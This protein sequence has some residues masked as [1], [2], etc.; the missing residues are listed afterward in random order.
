MKLSKSFIATAVLS[1][2]SV[3]NLSYAQSAHAETSTAQSSISVS[4]KATL[5]TVEAVDQSEILLSVIALHKSHDM[6]FTH[7][8]KMMVDEHG[9]NLAQ[10]LEMAKTSTPLVSPKGIAIAAHGQNTLAKLGGLQ[11]K[12]FEVAY[13]NEMVA[14]HQAALDLLNEKLKDSADLP[15]IKQFLVDTQQA[16]Q[17]HLAHAK[18]LQAKL[19]S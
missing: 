9:N 11:G 17:K 7:F 14:G 6:R 12:A 8:A 13:I 10:L 5:A 18:K 2:L 16:V 15:N 1:A 19:Q 3:V 4:E